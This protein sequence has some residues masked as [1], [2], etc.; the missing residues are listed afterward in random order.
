MNE[1]LILFILKIKSANI[2]EIKKFIDENFAPFL[3]VSTG[4]IIPALKRL[5]KNGVICSEKTISDGGLR[6]TI[7]SINENGEV[8]FNKLLQTEIFGA[9]QLARR[10]I[11]VL[12]NLFNHQIFTLEQKILLKNK[13][14]SA[15]DTNLKIINKSL[16]N[17]IMNVEF[18][19]LEQEF[20]EA[21]KKLLVIEEEQEEASLEITQ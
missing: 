1:F 3:Q 19:T 21:C 8:L 10:E 4:A 15:I 5:E 13:I 20:Y 7:Y 14:I 12:I 11:E 18:L 6:K 9:P 17:K 2:Y 16:Q